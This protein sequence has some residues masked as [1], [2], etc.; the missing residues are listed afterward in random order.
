MPSRWIRYTQFVGDLLSNS[1]ESADYQ[2]TRANW[3]LYVATLDSPFHL[4]EKVEKVVVWRSGCAH[5]SRF[6]GQVLMVW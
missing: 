5:I 4:A 3:P 1:C 6:S 2:I